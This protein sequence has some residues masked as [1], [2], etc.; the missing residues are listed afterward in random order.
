MGFGGG[1]GFP[2]FSGLS[3]QIKQC[4]LLAV[5]GEAW[6]DWWFGLRDVPQNYASRSSACW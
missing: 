2:L 6:V 5:S 4:L 1:S 3:D